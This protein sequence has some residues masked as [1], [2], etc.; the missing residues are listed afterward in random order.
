MSLKGPMEWEQLAS[1]C[2]GHLHQDFVA[3]HG[4]A[5]KAVQAWLAEASRDDAME[6]SSEWRSFLNVTHGMSLEA[7]AAALRELAGGSWAPA[8]ELEFEVVSALLLNAW[9][10]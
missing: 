8:N 9:R 2:G 3:E 5:Q 4:S 10:A 1:L 6:L 7:R